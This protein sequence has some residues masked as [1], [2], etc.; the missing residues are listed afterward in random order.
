[1]ERALT[2]SGS[3]SG[4]TMPGKP[5]G[6]KRSRGETVSNRS[7]AERAFELEWR[8]LGILW[9]EMTPEWMFHP[10]RQWRFD[11]AWRSRLVALELDGRGLSHQGIVG[12]RRDCEKLNEAARLGW[13]VLRF[14]SCDWKD[15]PEWAQYV[16]GLL[17]YS[18]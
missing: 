18:E 13:R 10:E 11:F 1:M 9:P 17:L 6:K 16:A 14:P 8:K 5:L 7:Q 3:E 15:A 12:Q 4:L 2:S